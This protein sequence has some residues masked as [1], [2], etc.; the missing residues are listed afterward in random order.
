[1]SGTT[2]EKLRRARTAAPAV[3][4]LARRQ[5]NTILHEMAELISAHR[6]EILAAN[7]LDLASD[8]SALPAATACSLNPARLAA[9]AD[10]I[11]A[12]ITLPDPVGEVVAE[13]VR[14]NGLRI[15]KVRV[16]LGVVGVIYESRPT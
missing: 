12:V 6:E 2:Q 8:S 10:G 15:R 13:W 3:A 5:K 1:M 4:Y 7:K 9:M 16:P 14:P 11:R